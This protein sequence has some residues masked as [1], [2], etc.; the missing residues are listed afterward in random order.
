MNKTE[1]VKAIAEKVGCTQKD[2]AAALKATVDVV[3]EALKN[4]EE[5]QL[6]GLGTFAVRAR[7]ARTSRNPATGASIKIAAKK[8]PV[9]KVSKT[10]KEAVN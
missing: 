5:V 9:F 2:A 6:Y 10:L 8:A 1:L 7:A 4:G 3:T